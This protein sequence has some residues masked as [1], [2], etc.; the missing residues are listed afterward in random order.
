[1]PDSDFLQSVPVV[2][3]KIAGTLC[4]KSESGIFGTHLQKMQNSQ[5]P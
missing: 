5:I 3:R 4:K 2:S 1:M